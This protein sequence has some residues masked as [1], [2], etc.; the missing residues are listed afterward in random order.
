M[1]QPINIA[2]LGATGAVG[3]AIF[4]ILQERQFPV[5]EIFA[6]ASAESAGERISFKKKRITVQ[7]AEDFDLGNYMGDEYKGHPCYGLVGID[8][9]GHASS[10]VG[11]ENTE[12]LITF[13]EEWLAG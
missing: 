7:N 11:R 4:K 10:D 2:V 5:G 8:P 3:E 1:T 12:R 9:R 13:L 6:L